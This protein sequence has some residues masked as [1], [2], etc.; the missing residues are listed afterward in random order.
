MLQRI[1]LPDWFRRKIAAEQRWRCV[2]C[3]E[4][5]PYTFEVDHKQ[6]LFQGGD[7]RRD[8]LQALCNG[9]HAS[10]TVEERTLDKQRKVD[11]PC[12]VCGK[13]VSHYFPHG[14]QQCYDDEA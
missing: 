4:L 2:I 3:R 1:S 11:G 13:V 7:N 10:K 6:A 5:L 9:C 14:A 12:L 8:N